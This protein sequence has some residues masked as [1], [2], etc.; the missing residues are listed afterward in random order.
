MLWLGIINILQ[1]YCNSSYRSPKPLE[2]IVQVP[3]IHKEKVSRSMNL[4]PLNFDLFSYF[5]DNCC[6]Y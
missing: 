3:E 5:L 2:I 4:V 6:K 1:L